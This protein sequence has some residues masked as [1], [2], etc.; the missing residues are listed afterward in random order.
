[1]FFQDRI[2]LVRSTAGMNEIQL[3]PGSDHANVPKS[4]LDNKKK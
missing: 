2:K 4:Y 1:M 3:C